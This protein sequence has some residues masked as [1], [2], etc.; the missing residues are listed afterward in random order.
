MSSVALNAAAIDL[1][2]ELQPMG[3]KVKFAIRLISP[4]NTVFREFKSPLG[5]NAHS[6][7]TEHKI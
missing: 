5:T 6:R 1:L 4:E 2:Q 3:T 7:L